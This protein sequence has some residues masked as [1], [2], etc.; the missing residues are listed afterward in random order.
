MIQAIPDQLG[1]PDL[2]TQGL[3]SLIIPCL[4]ISLHAMLFTY[5]NAHKG[6]EA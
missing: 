2:L 1:I 4:C 5:K 3:H 6:V